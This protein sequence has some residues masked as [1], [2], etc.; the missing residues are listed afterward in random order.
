MRAFSRMAAS[1]HC[2]NILAE[3]ARRARVA[4]CTVSCT[5][6]R[7]GLRL[8]FAG[9]T[10][11]ARFT[12][13]ISVHDAL[14]ERMADDVLAPEIGE[15]DPTHFFQHLLCIEEPAFLPFCEIHLGNV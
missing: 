1:T 10:R 8:A 15:S 14:H 13:F 3:G 11:A 5:R 6:P 2:L 4:Y 12:V 9:C 7:R